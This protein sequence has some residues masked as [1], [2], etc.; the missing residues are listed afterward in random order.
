MKQRIIS[1]TISQLLIALAVAIL[2]MQI[3]PVQEYTLKWPLT[4]LAVWF[5]WWA[6]VAYLRLDRLSLFDVTDRYQKQK[7]ESQT[8]IEA[9]YF[10]SKTPNFFNYIFTPVAKNELNNETLRVRI[11]SN[12]ICFI[13]LLILSFLF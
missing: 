13:V 7:E 9:S 10:S 4:F 5:L 3:R 11:Y 2:Y 6:W 8:K 12:A 1:K